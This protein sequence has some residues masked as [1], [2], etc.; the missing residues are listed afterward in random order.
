MPQNYILKY[1]L[2]NDE[3]LH[4]YKIHIYVNIHN[5]TVSNSPQMETNQM[6]I[7]GR[8]EKYLVIYSY[9][10]IVTYQWE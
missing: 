5:T 3:Q 2:N 7:I 6:F 1:I 9:K 8:I 10:G 4:I